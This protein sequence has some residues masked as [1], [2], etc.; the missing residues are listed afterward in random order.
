MRK[1]YA[2][3]LVLVI[4]LAFFMHVPFP[5][6]ATSRTIVVPDDY[7]TINSAIG[8]ATDGDT[9]F[10]RKGTHEGP[11]NQTILI[12]RPLSIIGESAESTIINLRPLYNVTWI[13]TQPFYSYSDAIKI[14]ANDVNLLN[15][16][17]A[18]SPGGDISASGHR[19]QIIGNNIKTE[20]S[21]TGLVVSGSYCHITDNFSSGRVLL[22][23]YSNTDKGNAVCGIVLDH[24]GWTII[25]LNTVKYLIFNRT[26]HNSIH[27]NIVDSIDSTI[28]PAVRVSISSH[29]IFRGNFIDV[30]I[31]GVNLAVWGAN[32]TFYH[33]SFVGESPVSVSSTAYGSYGNVWD[34]GA[35]GNFWSNYEGA[36]LNW[37][38]IGESP[39][40]IDANNV[41]R[42]PLMEPWSEDAPQR[43]LEVFQTI[44]IV[45]IIAVLVVVGAVLALY[46]RR[47][48]ASR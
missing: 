47:K 18:I 30:G 34:N 28:S 26:Y 5:V 15:L 38:G 35:Q 22:T 40:V 3:L 36:D 7:P 14:K 13:L 8:N 32:N 41:D 44:L 17:I 42:Y 10:I 21:T 48:I 31:Y 2:T 43:G 1:K 37:D 39:Y 12:G 20:S 27:E 46:F 11:V 23:G 16:T 33:N 24:G 25:G 45:I 9:I 19:I 6:N 4:S 29:S